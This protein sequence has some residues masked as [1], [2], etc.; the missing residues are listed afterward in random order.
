MLLH[1]KVFADF[2]E[3]YDMYSSQWFNNLGA[4]LTELQSERIVRLKQQYQESKDRDTKAQIVAKSKP[5]VK[6]I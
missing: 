5:I 6:R 4:R 1:Q 3:Q 2:K